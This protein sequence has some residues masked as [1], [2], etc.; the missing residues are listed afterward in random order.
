MYVESIT[1]DQTINDIFTKIRSNYDQT[2]DFIN[3]NFLE[4]GLING[5]IKNI[6]YDVNNIKNDLNEMKRNKFD[7]SEGL[8]NCTLNK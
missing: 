5:E 7:V 8:N 6:K 4:I 2:T 3:K 1:F